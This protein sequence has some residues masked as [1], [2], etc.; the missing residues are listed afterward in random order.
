MVSGK[1]AEDIK[2]MKLA[3]RLSREGLGYTEPN[4]LVGAVVVKDNQV[5]S[6]GYHRRF[7][8]DHAERT[9]L[10][11][12]Y[13]TDTTLYVTLEPCIHFGKTPPCVDLLKEKKVKR[14]VIAMKDPN[15]VINGKG[16]AWCK[17]NGMA[18]KV[19]VLAGSAEKINRHYLKYITQKRPYVALKAGISIDGK[20]TDKFFK[21]Q[22]I[23]DLE[24]RD[25]AHNLRGEFSAIL[26][27]AN[28]VRSDDPLLTIRDKKWPEKKLYRV[29]LDTQNT[30]DSEFKIFSDREQF[31]LILFS[32]KKDKNRLARADTHFFVSQDDDDKLNLMEILGKL[33]QLGIASVLVEGGG[34]MINSF[35]KN[36]IVDEIILFQASKLIGGQQSIEL[37]SSG[38]G[39]ST[40]LVLKEKEVIELKNGLIIRGFM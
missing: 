39:L 24:L 26:V 36:N 17:E 31:P 2:Y 15:P 23:T 14:V 33:F 28:T 13:K 34:D 7:G 16:I 37:F 35:L 29:V 10:K 8:D 11:D 40:P 32:S 20:L 25:V 3:L 30:L 12:V 5:I 6:T 27:G 19:G 38:V 18:V 21:S 9:A 22:W 1:E 4:P